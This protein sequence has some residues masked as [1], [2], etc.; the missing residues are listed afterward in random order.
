MGWQLRH[1]GKLKTVCGG[2]PNAISAITGQGRMKAINGREV[3]WKRFLVVAW[4]CIFYRNIARFKTIQI[5]A[6]FTW[7]KV[8]PSLQLVD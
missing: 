3:K 7:L 4:Y 1:N 8:F 2:R 6:L 5:N